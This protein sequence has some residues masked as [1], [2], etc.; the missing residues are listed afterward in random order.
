ME[1]IIKLRDL[2]KSYGP[3]KAVDCLNLEI[4]PGEI[5]GLLGPNGAGKTTSILM[6]LGLTEP[7]SGSAIVCGY[8]ATRNPISVKRKVGYMPDNV[9]FYP[10]MTGMENLLYIARLNGLDEPG[11]A[12]R[13]KTVLGLVGLEAAAEKRTSTYSRGMKQRLGLADVLIKAPELIILDEPTLGIDPTG[14]REF[15]DLIKRLREEQGLTVLLSSHHLHHVQQVCDRVGI[16][17]GGKLLA[18]GDLTSLSAELFGNTGIQ[19]TI[20]LTR[21]PKEAERLKLEFSRLQLITDFNISGEILTFFSSEDITPRL[22]RMLIEHGE[23]IQRISHKEY[24][25]DEIYQKYFESSS[26]KTTEN[27]RS[28]RNSLF[29]R[30]RQ[31]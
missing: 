12:K 5:F 18:H 14:V 10:H 6:M 8:D 4:N 1:P 31:K 20:Q 26:S 21:S 19:T 25:L 11:I 30:G 7:D 16:F 9:G 3:Y 27:E 15:L 17:V 2:S 29:H 28:I 24:G 13:A 23:D 22:I